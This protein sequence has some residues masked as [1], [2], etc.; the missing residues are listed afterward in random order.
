[1]TTAYSRLVYFDHY[2]HHCIL[3]NNIID[4]AGA[5]KVF[6][7]QWRLPTTG[8]F[9]A[10][11]SA[12]HALIVSNV[13]RNLNAYI[14]VFLGGDSNVVRGNILR[15]GP[16]GDFFNVFGR[17]HLITGNIC[18]NMPP[19]S[20]N[21][22][23]FIQTWGNN[24]Y[25]SR[26]HIIENNVV[27]DIA[28]GQLT[29][30]EGNTLPETRDWTFRNNLFMRIAAQGSGT[31]PDVRYYNNVF[32]KCNHVNG[33][34][35]ISYGIRWYE[36]FSIPLVSPYYALTASAIP[37][38][39][40]LNDATEPRDRRA[41]YIV[42]NGRISYNG[43]TFGADQYFFG[44]NV[45]AYSKVDAAAEVWRVIPNYADGNVLMNNI[46]LDCG[47]PNAPE[48]GWYS[49][50]TSL[51]NVK[52]DYNYVGKD[53]F[54]AVNVDSQQRPVGAAGGWS[55]FDWWEPNGINGGNP[56][57]MDPILLN[58]RLREDSMLRSRG[59]ALPAVVLD[60]DGKVRPN[61]P[62]IGA[63]EFAPGVGL[64]PPAGLRILSGTP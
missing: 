7:V 42:K 17:N 31:I 26:G 43:S 48:K 22:P 32:Y 14:F 25:A 20:G 59:L 2:A 56:G 60:F 44:T 63:F 61:P 36:N 27:S 62:S 10:G 34:H 24:G 8:P 33:G 11:E 53:N 50:D 13:I 41:R 52:A 21:H 38:G 29:Q 1:V 54:S 4:V 9:G 55:N 5:Y 37:S 47:F 57:V 51:L 40:I 64:T 16:Q 6:G 18:S 58:F 49:L 30:L 39:S 15:D 46:F 19:G 28:S 3:S 45:T 23:D 12:S 35:A